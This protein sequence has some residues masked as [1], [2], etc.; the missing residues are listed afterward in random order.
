MLSEAL[1]CHAKGGKQI[2]QNREYAAR[3]TGDGM[4][5]GCIRDGRVLACIDEGTA[6][7]LHYD[8]CHADAI[9]IQ[10]TRIVSSD[11]LTGRSTLFGFGG[12]SAGLRP[13][14]ASSQSA[15]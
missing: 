2:L 8:V 1:I 15:M 3:N 7:H 14:V 12:D 13:P 5:Y 6:K 4:A 11:I 10:P 9:T